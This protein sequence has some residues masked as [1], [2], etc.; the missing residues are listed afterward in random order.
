MNLC[1]N[2]GNNKVEDSLQTLGPEDL[3]VWSL[4]FLRDLKLLT[5]LISKGALLDCKEPGTKSTLLHLAI[6]ENANDLNGSVDRFDILRQLLTAGKMSPNVPD[7]YGHTPLHIAALEGSVQATEIL[8][9]HK[10]KLE[11]LDR[12]GRTPLMISSKFGNLGV[13][14]TLIN[15]GAKIDEFKVDIDKL[16]LAAVANRNIKA[17]EQLL[18]ARADRLAQDDYGRTTDLIARQVGGME[19]LKILQGARS[20][21]YKSSKVKA[22]VEVTEVE[23]GEEVALMQTTIVPF[24]SPALD[25]EEPILCI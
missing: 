24:R 21:V 17:M 2:E 7:K 15:A 8:L 4:V 25:R 14:L 19:L 6:I 16:L 1:K 18:L 3:P 22:S 5:L 11:E 20:F 23:V 12:F 9:E 10:A 13:A